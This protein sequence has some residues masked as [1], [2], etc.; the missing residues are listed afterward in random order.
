MQ[1][2]DDSS[3]AS[4]AGGGY[5]ARHDDVE[6]T[7]LW[8]LRG[9]AMSDREWTRH[10]A[11]MSEIATWSAKRSLR[12]AVILFISDRWASPDAEQRAK[13]A[14]ASGAP[15]YDPYLAIVTRNVVARGVLRVLN[16]LTER[17]S[18]EAQVFA[19]E[20]EALAWLEAKR[21]LRLV[22]LRRWLNERR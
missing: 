19:D 18:Y 22:A 6:C 1:S 2:R 13:L 21:G 11:D 3:R 7:A 4:T 5:Q 20:Q 8:D 12:P 17:P 9:S 16:W 15:T 10:F 14:Q